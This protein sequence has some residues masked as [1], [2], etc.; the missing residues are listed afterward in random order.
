MKRKILCVCLSLFIC[1]SVVGCGSAE[2]FVV[3]ESFQIEHQKSNPE[4]FI[5]AE[6]EKYSLK[7]D[8]EKKT[9][10]SPIRT[11]RYPHKRIRRADSY[12]SKST[13]IV[14]TLS[15][16]KQTVLIWP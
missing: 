8:S 14:R 12:S 3:Q 2:N 16:V 9:V 5:A 1:L 6:N 7:W 10:A 15:F 11:K 4:S 13:V